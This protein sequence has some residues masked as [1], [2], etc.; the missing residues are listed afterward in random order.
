[1]ARNTRGIEP[2]CFMRN[3]QCERLPYY[4]RLRFGKTRLHALSCDLYS[5]LEADIQLWHLL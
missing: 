5:L 4:A 1:M 2:K 3:T